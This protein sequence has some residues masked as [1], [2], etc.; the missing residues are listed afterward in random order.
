MPSHRN[1]MFPAS[2]TLTSVFFTTK[3]TWNALNTSMDF[4]VKARSS[5]VD[6]DVS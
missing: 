3:A 2:P 4:K 6:R 5:A 1:I